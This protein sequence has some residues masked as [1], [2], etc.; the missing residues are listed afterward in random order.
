M[1]DVAGV[2]KAIFFYLFAIHDFITAWVLSPI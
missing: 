1:V 2:L